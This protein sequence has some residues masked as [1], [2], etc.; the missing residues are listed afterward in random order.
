MVA[1]AVADTKRRDHLTKELARLDL[2]VVAAAYR[3]FDGDTEAAAWLLRPLH[4]LGRKEPV[5]LARSK[6]GR[7]KV[8]RLLGA[9]ELGVFM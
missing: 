8:L 2:D 3:C 5:V 7:Q 4:S 9:I 1:A 6:A